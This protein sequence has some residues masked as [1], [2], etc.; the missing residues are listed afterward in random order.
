VRKTALPFLLRKKSKKPVGEAE[1]DVSSVSRTCLENS[2]GVWYHMSDKPKKPDQ[3]F[4]LKG[5]P[6]VSGVLT[7]SP[8]YL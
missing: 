8:Y 2:Q 3:Y 4:L 5:A 7:S 1:Y 6:N